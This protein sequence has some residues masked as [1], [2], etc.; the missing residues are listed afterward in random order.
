MKTD[1]LHGIAKWIDHNRYTAAA[2]GL[3]VLAAL[4]ITACQPTTLSPISGEKVTADQLQADAVGWAAS[5]EAEATTADAEHAAALAALDPESP[6]YAAQQA[7]EIAAH[8]RV[9]SKIGAEVTGMAAKVEAAAADLER[10]QNFLAN[11]LTGIGTLAA[12]VA[13][14][15][16]SEIILGLLSLGGVTLATGIK[17]DNTRK[18]TVIAELKGEQAPSPSAG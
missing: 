12:Q 9:I 16:W 17:L 10:Q 2:I 6:D 5:K 4:L 11:A 13:P 15:P 14:P 8:T 18:D 7:A 3:V 1:F